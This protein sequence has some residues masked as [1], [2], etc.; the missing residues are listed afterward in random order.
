MA[1][2]AGGVIRVLLVDDQRELAET[3]AEYMEDHHDDLSVVI[4]DSAREGIRTL[5]DSIDCIVSDYDMPGRNGLQFLRAIR[6]DY[7]DLPFILLTGKG[8]EEVAA[9]AISAGVTDYVRK[10]GGTEQ[11]E[12][13]AN[14]IVN[15]VGKHHAEQEARET[16]QRLRNLF[17]R[18]TDAFISLDQDWRVIH[19]NNAAEELFDRKRAE[20]LDEVFWVAFPDAIGTQF[21]ERLEAAVEEGEPVTF[22]EFYPPL[23]T[24][25]YVRLYPSDDGVSLY[26]RRVE[27][28]MNTDNDP[29]TIERQFEA[30]FEGTSDPMLFVDDNGVCVDANPAAAELLS[31]PAEELVDDPLARYTRDEEGLGVSWTGIAVDDEREGTATFAPP[32]ESPHTLAF[33]VTATFPGRF[34]LTLEPT[35][36]DAESADDE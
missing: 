1:E 15:V 5:D 27:D 33:E 9:E 36:D 26:V 25:L 22:E 11:F 23:F 12:V 16:A 31:I 29:Q 21:Q 18:I 7:P 8:S 34:L 6:D 17:D 30:V 19:L 2:F 13:L 3:A 24:W 4:A 14:R 10:Q 28:V 35:E 32:D 20:L